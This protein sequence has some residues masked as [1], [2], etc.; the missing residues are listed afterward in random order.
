MRDDRVRVRF[1]DLSRLLTEDID[2][3]AD[4]L[5]QR[6]ALNEVDAKDTG[7]VLGFQLALEAHMSCVL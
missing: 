2:G 3:V 4:K 5:G 1:Y 7:Q 6:I